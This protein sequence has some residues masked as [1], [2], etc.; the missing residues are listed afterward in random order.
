LHQLVQPQHPHFGFLAAKP[1]GRLT[2][3]TVYFGKK[4]KKHYSDGQYRQPFF[5]YF[6]IH[7]LV[8]DRKR[9]QMISQ[10]MSSAQA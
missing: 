4:L 5:K 9:E 8:F 2:N 1:D 7:T 10:M 3:L 6:P